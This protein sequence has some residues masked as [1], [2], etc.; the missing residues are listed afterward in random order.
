MN[1]ADGCYSVVLNIL[2]LVQ[3]ANLLQCCG[4][5]DSYGVMVSFGHRRGSFLLASVRHFLREMHGI[6]SQDLIQTGYRALHKVSH[7]ND[8]AVAI[9]ARAG[10][11]IVTYE[12]KNLR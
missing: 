1:C 5:G 3:D 6:S 10:L 4:W 2:H 11:K 12:R 9:V 7:F 8:V